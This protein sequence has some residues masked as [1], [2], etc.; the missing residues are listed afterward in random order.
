MPKTIILETT[1]EKCFLQKLQNFRYERN[2]LLN[3]LLF[4]R[5]VDVSYDKIKDML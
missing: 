4:I 3:V 1:G 5:D 2:T